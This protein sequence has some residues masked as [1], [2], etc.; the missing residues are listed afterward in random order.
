MLRCG[1]RNYTAGWRKDFIYHEDAELRAPIQPLPVTPEPPSHAR[2]TEPI[3]L[4]W[5]RAERRDW[6]YPANL[7]GLEPN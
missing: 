3:R 5:R 2:T 1:R 4:S 6:V 7:K